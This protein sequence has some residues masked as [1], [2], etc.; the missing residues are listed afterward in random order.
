MGSIFS[1]EDNL[2]EFFNFGSDMNI[3]LDACNFHEGSTAAGN[4]SFYVKNN[5]PPITLNVLIEG[6]ENVFSEK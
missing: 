3:V 1:S 2:K 6:H 5:C 4:V